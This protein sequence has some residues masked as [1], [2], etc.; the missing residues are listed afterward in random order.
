MILP[1]SHAAKHTKRMMS[2]LFMSA[3]SA[4]ECTA[5]GVSTTK[6]YVLNAPTDDFGGAV[7]R[8]CYPNPTIR[9]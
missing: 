8:A 9:C 1:V 6:V 2:W 7:Y 4:G 3:G 5:M